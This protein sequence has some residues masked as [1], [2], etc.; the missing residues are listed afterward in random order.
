MKNYFYLF[1]D[2]LKPSIRSDKVPEET[3][4]SMVKVLVG[5]TFKNFVKKSKKDLVIAL[6]KNKESPLFEAFLNLIKFNYH[7]DPN[8]VIAKMDV[9]N[10]DFT[11]EFDSHQKYP[12]LFYV[13]VNDKNNPVLY[14]GEMEMKQMEEFIEKTK[15][16]FEKLVK[17][18]QELKEDKPVVKKVKEVKPTV[19]DSTCGDESELC[20]IEKSNEDKIVNEHKVESL[21]EEL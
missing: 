2:T 19:K 1:E 5:K 4:D 12:C 6:Y 15:K 11:K 17:H 3:S 8:L 10:N 7:N 16:K 18:K 14:A 13:H 21:K 20:S 9:L